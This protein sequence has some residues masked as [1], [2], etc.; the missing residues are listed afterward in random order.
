M[1]VEPIQSC[2]LPGLALTAIAIA[3]GCTGPAA[4]GPFDGLYR[5]S[6]T[7]DCTRVGGDGGALRI[8]DD[9]LFG[10]NSQCRMTGPVNVRDM[11][12]VLYD[13]ACSGNGEAWTSRALFMR[14]AEDGGL[15]IA[16]DGH[17]FRYDSCAPDAPR[18]TVTMSK[19]I[20]IVE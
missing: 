7:S 13:M 10:L 11:D 18:G 16:W 14:A 6:P 5:S 19:D 20:G 2:P 3:M 1:A 9:V 8:G 12:A 4:A 17:A 15:I